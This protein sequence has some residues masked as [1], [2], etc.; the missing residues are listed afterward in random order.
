[1]RHFLQKS[2]QIKND[3]KVDAI[4]EK[5]TPHLFVSNIYKTY[6]NESTLILFT[7]SKYNNQF[8][9]SHDRLLMKKKFI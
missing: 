2:K 8:E 7:K 9:L 1:M 6:I 5:G 3:S 4:E